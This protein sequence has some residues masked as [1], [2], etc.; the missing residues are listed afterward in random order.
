MTDAKITSEL[1]ARPPIDTAYR[2]L[3]KAQR[4]I[5]NLKHSLEQQRA[6]LT[7]YLFLVK[8]LRDE[9]TRLRREN[10]SLREE[11]CTT[12]ALVNRTAIMNARRVDE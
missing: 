3:V 10:S 8:E 1:R 5:E 11:L 4:T 12:K 6:G 9:N 2:Q 7:N